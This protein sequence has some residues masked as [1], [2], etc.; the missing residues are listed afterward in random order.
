VFRLAPLAKTAGGTEACDQPIFQ[1][2]EDPDY[3]KI[4][5]TFSPLRRMVEQRPRMDMP[6]ADGVCDLKLTSIQGQ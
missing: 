2:R 6:G 3:V 4:L 5:E 1:S